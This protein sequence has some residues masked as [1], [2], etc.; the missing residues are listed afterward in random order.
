[1]SKDQALREALKRSVSTDRLPVLSQ[2]F[3]CRVMTSVSQEAVLRNGR[4][5]GWMVFLASVFLLVGMGL[6][7]RFYFPVQMAS[8]FSFPQRLVVDT[9]LAGG[10]AFLGV[11]VLF[12]LSLDA[13]LRLRWQRLDKI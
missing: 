5:A 6:L 8:L 2:D 9:S 11:I 10:Y 12:L 13:F 3:E 7:L 1:M 4:H